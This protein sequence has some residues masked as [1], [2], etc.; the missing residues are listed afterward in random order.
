MDAKHTHSSAL[1]A[2]V[3][4][5]GSRLKDIPRIEE[6]RYASPESK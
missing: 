1:G 5:V 6:I 4:P 3:P 2:S